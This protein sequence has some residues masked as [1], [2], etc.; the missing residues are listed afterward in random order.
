MSTLNV[1]IVDDSIL[2][3]K[4][5]EA[6]IAGMGHQV[7]RSVSNGAQALVA[8]RECKPDIVTMDIT[9]P[10]VDGIEATRQILAE[11]PEAKVIMVTSHGQEGMIREAIKAGAV[12]YVM[13]PVKAEK[14]AEY[15]RSA[16]GA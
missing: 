10:E 9:M 3:L 2:M 11:F 12:G 5:L 13:K 8:Y 14:L 4:K 7:C 15:I 16:V 6:L 1:M